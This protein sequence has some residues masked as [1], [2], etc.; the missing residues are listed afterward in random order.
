MCQKVIQTDYESTATRWLPTLNTGDMGWPPISTRRRWPHLNVNGNKH[1]R[2]ISI[3]KLTIYNVY[4]PLSCNWTPSVLPGGTF[5]SGRW[6]TKKSLDLRFVSEDQD[7]LLL[8]LNRVI[9]NKF[10][11]S[12]HCPAIV[13]VGIIIP[14]IDKPP[15]PGWNFRLVCFFKI[16]NKL[17]PNDVSNILFK[18]SNIRPK[19]YKKTKIKCEYKTILNSCVERSEIMQDFNAADIEMALSLVKNGKAAGVDRVLPEFI[20]HIGP[21]GKLRLTNLFSY[22]KNTATL[23]KVW[24]KAKVIATLKPVTLPKEQAGFRQNRNCCGQVL[25]MV[26]HVKNGFQERRKSGAVFLDLTCA[27][28]TVWKRGLLLKLANILNCKMSLRL[29]ESMLADRKFRV[30]LNGNVS[31]YKYLQNG[32][33]QSSVLSPILFNAYTADITRIISRKTTW[34]W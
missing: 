30:H 14:T 13:S 20:K 31:R 1:F 3:G 11:K 8:S 29:I 34:G 27:Y 5:E 24:H 15:M 23:P 26:T 21:K 7:G 4:K 25:P 12:Q 18:T 6:G 2:S 19:E 32:L 22:V 33:P 9:K 10:P 16:K 17:P 28:D